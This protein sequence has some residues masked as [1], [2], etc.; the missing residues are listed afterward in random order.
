MDF[1]KNL[2]QSD[3]VPSDNNYCGGYAMAAILNDRDDTDQWNPKAVYD[4]LLKQQTEVDV[5]LQNMLQTKKLNG[6]DIVLPSSLM[7]FAY[8]NGFAVEL[9]YAKSLPFL[10]VIIQAE[11]QRCQSKGTVKELGSKAT[12]LQYFSDESIK[13]SLVLISNHNHWVAVKRKSDNNH[14]SVYNPATGVCNNVND[15]SELVEYLGSIDS[16]AGDLIITLK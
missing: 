12:V 10:P 2:K 7:L 3:A 5:P 14:F 1:G 13:Y 16:A 8:A 9:L 11:K 6:T 15:G 4:S